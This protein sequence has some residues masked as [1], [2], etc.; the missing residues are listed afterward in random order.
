MVHRHRCLI[1]HVQLPRYALCPHS[2]SL[3]CIIVANGASLPVSHSGRTTIPTSTTPIHLRNVLVSPSLIKNLISIKTLCRD[4]PVNVEFDNFGFSIK[5][6]L[7]KMVILRCNCTGDLYPVR[8]PC[9]AHSLHA[10]ASTSTDVWHQ[11]L[12]HPGR[13]TLAHALCAID[14]SIPHL[15]SHT[16]HAC[17]IGKNIRFP[18]QDSHHVSYFPFQ[19]VH[20]DVWMSPVLSSSGFRYYLLILDD[21]S[22]FAWTF[23]LR[24]K[25][26][27]LAA[28]RRFH[29]MVATHFSLHVLTL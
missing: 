8:L 25:S 24:L 9:P 11:R 23:P 18:F 20:C 14:P 26:D 15:A 29:A 7:T 28:I 13:T 4:N 6:R 5:D 21:Y 10:S 2:F 16:C 19:L 3:S 17:Q 27:A 22:H 12:G 1:A